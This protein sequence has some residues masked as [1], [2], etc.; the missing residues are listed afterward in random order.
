MSTVPTTVVLDSS[1]ASARPGAVSLEEYYSEAGPDYAAW[2]R[3]FNMHFGYYRWGMNPFKR[4]P[5]LEQMN[6]EVLERLW[7]N[8]KTESRILDLGCGLGATLRS[9]AQRLPLASLTGV[10]RVPWQ[11]EH[12]R[13]RNAA[14]PHGDRIEIAQLDYEKTQLPSSSFDA[15]YAI[16]SACYAHGAEKA[17]FL[18]EAKRLLRPGGRLVMVDG[19]MRSSSC[20]HA[21]QRRIF[22]KLCECW[23]IE[24]WGELD[25][26][27][28]E[29]GMLGFRD[30]RVEECQFR[31]APSVC[32]IPWVTLQFLTREVLC[33]KKEMTRA[34]WNNVLAPVLLPLVSWP[35]G[36]MVYCIVS[37]TKE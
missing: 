27:K 18:K 13:E 8:P 36:P 9:L 2:S 31:V 32:H 1:P 22:D 24:S 23:V 7:I 19:F 26:L 35:L 21:M 29:L 25:L 3:E 30:I 6:V 28:A 15:A 14:T 11:V 37:A 33:G 10:T 16:E 17:A 34:R 4:E 20:M 12:A 5:M